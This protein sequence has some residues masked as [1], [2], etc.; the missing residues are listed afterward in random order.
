MELQEFISSVSKELEDPSIN[1]QRKRYLESYINDLLEYQ[2]QN[3]TAK[4]TPSQ[5]QLFCFLNPDSLE[6]RIYDD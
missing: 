2:K 6:C 3:P 4:E 5:F 1:K